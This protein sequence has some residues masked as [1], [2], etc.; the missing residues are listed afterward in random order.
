MTYWPI[1]SPSVFAATKHTNPERARVSNDGL[2]DGARHDAPDDSPRPGDGDATVAQGQAAAEE[3][4]RVPSSRPS[5]SDQLIE[6][7]IHGEIIAVRVTR[8]GHMFAT[9][10]QSTLTIWQT[11]A[12]PHCCTT[13]LLLI[14]YIAHGCSRFR[15]ALGAIGK[16]IRPQYRHSSSPRLP[17]LCGADNA[18]LPHHLLPCDRPRFSR[19]QNP[20]YKHTRWALKAQQ[21][22]IRIQA[23]APA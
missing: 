11:K 6:D 21:Y 5:P 3:E 14:R 23:A 20:V 1:S 17:D 9:L 4:K 7:D 13:G 12:R 10:T 19:I 15:L 2:D 16:D 22:H 18:R 8:S